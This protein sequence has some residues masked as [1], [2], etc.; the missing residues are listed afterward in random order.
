MLLLGRRYELTGALQFL[1]LA[2]YRVSL[3]FREA[4]S[5]VADV[6]QLCTVKCEVCR[7]AG[8]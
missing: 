5:T 6:Q 4:P 8:A 3:A 7:A 2:T 1:R